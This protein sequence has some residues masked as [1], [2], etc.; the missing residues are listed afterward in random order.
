MAVKTQ[1]SKFYYSE[2]GSVYTEIL[3]VMELPEIGGKPG[4]IDTTDLASTIKTNMPGLKDPGDMAFKFI[5]DNSGATSNFRV[6]KGLETSEESDN[7]SDYFKVLYDDGTYVIWRGYVT[8]S[9]DSAKVDDKLTFTANISA[10][11]DFTWTN[12]A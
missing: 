10:S 12:P 6:L 3:G 1:G 8:V 5:F 4:K 9:M 11:T 7:V 2:A